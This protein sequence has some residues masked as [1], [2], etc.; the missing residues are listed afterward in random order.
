[1]VLLVHL[2]RKVLSDQKEIKVHQ[3]HQGLLVYQDRR[4]RM[5]KRVQL[6]LEDNLALQ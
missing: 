2:G 6:D 3:A 5:V 1:M 4:E